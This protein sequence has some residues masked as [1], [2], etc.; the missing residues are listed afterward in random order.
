M[1]SLKTFGGLHAKCSKC[2]GIVTQDYCSG[3]CSVYGDPKQDQTREE[4]LHRTCC[5]CGYKWLEK[6]ADNK[7][8]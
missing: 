8:E 5:M 4:H 7:P 3:N 1:T 6:C 2:G